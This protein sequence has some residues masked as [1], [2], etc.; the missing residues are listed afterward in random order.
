MI[1][2]IGVGWIRGGRVLAGLPMRKKRKIRVGKCWRTRLSN[3]TRPG[4]AG[5]T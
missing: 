1:T 5:A 4:G 2:W 3:R